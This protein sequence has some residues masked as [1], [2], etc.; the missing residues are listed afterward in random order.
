MVS[1]KMRKLGVLPV[2]RRMYVRVRPV[3]VTYIAHSSSGTLYVLSGQTR[4][5][6][7]TF[8]LFADRPLQFVG[9]FSGRARFKPW[10]CV[11]ILR[12]SVSWPNPEVEE[13]D[14]L[15]RK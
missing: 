13:Y 7:E 8:S 12:D 14:S 9:G 4:L 6:G 10:N 1:M 15:L 3:T 2:E 5:K 11:A